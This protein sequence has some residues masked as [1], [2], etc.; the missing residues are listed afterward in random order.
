MIN[1]MIFTVLRY[2]DLAPLMELDDYISA[3]WNAK[4]YEAGT[5]EIQCETTPERLAKVIR[6][7]YIV[8]NG[9]SEIGI[10]TTIQYTRDE[11]RGAVMTISGSFAQSLLGRRI[12][13][14]KKTLSS[15]IASGLR[16]LISDNAIAPTDQDRKICLDRIS[17][18]AE[19]EVISVA[20]FIKAERINIVSHCDLINPGEDERGK[21]IG[22]EYACTDL[23]G[24][25][26]SQGGKEKEFYFVPMST[27]HKLAELW[28][29]P[30]SD[31]EPTTI[32]FDRKGAYLYTFCHHE[33]LYPDFCHSTTA[34]RDGYTWDDTHRVA[35][36]VYQFT[37]LEAEDQ[38]VLCNG[39][40][41]LTKEQFNNGGF[42]IA[43]FNN[44][45][46]IRV[47]VP[48]VN[49][50]W[51]RAQYQG[52]EEEQ[53]E[54]NS[55]TARIMLTMVFSNTVKGSTIPEQ[56]MILKPEFW[57]IFDLKEQH[58]ERLSAVLG[59]SMIFISDLTAPIELS[60]NSA[61]PGDMFLAYTVAVGEMTDYLALGSTPSISDPD[62][63][64]EVLGDNLLSKIEEILK[65]YGAAVRARYSKQERKILIDFYT[66]ARRSSAIIY[67]E[68]LDN[69]ASYDVAAANPAAN[70]ALVYSELENVEY[71]AEAGISAGIRRFE[72]FE[73]KK[74]SP[75][76]TGSDYERQLAQE[77]TISL[78]TLD[79]AI[80]ADVNTRAYPYRD[81]RGLNL[82]DIV[83]IAIKELNLTY[84]ARVLE[85]REYQDNTGYSIDLV[86]GE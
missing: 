67:S 56:Y 20:D 4:Y 45:L 82:G 34:S 62:F 14:D 18:S 71:K 32:I 59:G 83:S 31:N 38:L 63:T 64:L 9:T 57:A 29:N 69:L 51:A 65:S 2:S 49:Y 75:G 79:L 78:K 53:A 43:L 76:Y 54:W 86:L 36:G 24:L 8:L 58:R 66:G 70:Y 60:L 52:N 50:N 80:T 30:Y 84:E 17:E 5:F 12:I 42:G 22:F 74:D 27:A 21:L 46:H 26:A 72:T 48:L 16:A 13:W 55:N 40:R 19:G 33:I 7:N 1:R 39:F 44:A 61:Y 28:D 6:D 47:G 37:D 73:N 85:V 81:P 10:I 68:R 15:D 41:G 35:T 23:T 11:E 3:I 25:K 77:G